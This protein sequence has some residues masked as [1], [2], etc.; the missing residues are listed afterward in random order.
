MGYAVTEDEMEQR[1]VATPRVTLWSG[2]LES[3]AAMPQARH[4][5]SAALQRAGYRRQMI[6][7]VALIITELTVN[8][9]THGATGEVAVEVGQAETGEGL[10]IRTAHDEGVAGFG[11]EDPPVM[12]LPHEWAGRG[13]AI[14]AALSDRFE[15]TQ[16][17]P[18]RVAH[19]VVIHA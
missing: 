2:I 8:A 9:L 19:L 4:D 6:E 1:T 11:V 10:M 18:R 3:H 12:A 5:M 17:P 16:H 15:T 13:R 14:V 7:D